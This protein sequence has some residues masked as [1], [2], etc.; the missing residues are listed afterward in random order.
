MASPTK[1][2]PETQ[3]F[4]FQIV[5]LLYLTGVYA[6]GLALDVGTLVST[7]LWIIFC[8]TIWHANRDQKILALGVLCL[9]GCCCNPM[10]AGYTP[11]Y[12][13]RAKHY[14]CGNNQRQMM[15]AMLNY[16]SAH[17]VFPDGQPKSPTDPPYSWRVAILP[18]I[19]CQ[20]LYD[21]YDFSEP[22]DGP[23]NS[24]LLSQMPDTYRCPLSSGL[25]DG[26]TTYK[27]VTGPGT[28]FDE[29]VEPTFRSIR[30]GS[31]NTAAIVEDAANPVPWTKPEDIS[32]DQA[33]Q[34][35][36]K[37]FKGNAAHV[38]ETIFRRFYS[39]GNMAFYDGSTYRARQFKDPV[40][41]AK[42]FGISNGFANLD[43]AQNCS[44]S[45]SR[46]DKIVAAV[47]YVILILAPLF[48]MP[49]KSAQENESIDSTDVPVST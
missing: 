23:N 24:K 35:F 29:G 40:D 15:L 13:A 19:E 21:Q 46:Y 30:D 3:N 36:C 1:P 6:T 12:V 26:Q 33:V 20:D 7:S 49:W 31:S 42:L 28:L 8:A 11:R 10:P 22:W 17:L 43:N 2:Q 25:A 47:I 34:L 37:S 48:F 27:V 4:R 18:F 14:Q 5:H 32:I 39:S 41:A 38:R 16:E 45:E 9:F 44:W